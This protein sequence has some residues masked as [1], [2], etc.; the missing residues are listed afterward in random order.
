MTNELKK[1]PFCGGEVFA[2][3]SG[4]NFELCEVICKECG[5]RTERMTTVKAISAWNTRK[6]IDKIVEQLEKMEE[7]ALRVQNYDV[8]F[9]ATG[10]MHKA[11]E[12]VKGGVSDD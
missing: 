3:H 5:C 6:P 1:C 7:K 9:Y 10:Q 8:S 11:I 2:Y 12:I 4:L